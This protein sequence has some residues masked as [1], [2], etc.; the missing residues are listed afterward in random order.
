MV[1]ATARRGLIHRRAKPRQPRAPSIETLRRQ[2]CTGKQIA[3]EVGVSPATVSRILRRL[4]TEPA[5][6]PGAGRAGAPLRAREARRDDP[7]GHQEARPFRPS[8][9]PRHRRSPE[10]AKAA[11]PAG[12][13]STSASTTHRAWPSP[14]SCPTSRRR[15]PSPSWKRARG[16]DLREPRRRRRRGDDRQR[17]LLPIRSLPPRLAGSSASSTSA[18]GPTRRKPTA[19]PSASSRPPCGNGPTPRP[20]RPQIDAPQ[21]CLSG[22]ISYNWHRPH[23]GI[24][25]RH[26]SAVSA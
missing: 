5:K 15:A 12:S 6:R 25:S 1:C 19:R 18:P 9:P 20:T 7:H 26:P 2:R 14:R 13:S 8:R 10:Q 22:Y 11:A 23:G 17:L 16:F 4:G 21:N 24:K 3:A